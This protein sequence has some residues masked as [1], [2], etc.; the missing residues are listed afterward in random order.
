MPSINSRCLWNVELNH[1]TA[2]IL[3]Y[4][5]GAE[6][7][8]LGAASAFVHDDCR[9]SRCTWNTRGQASCAAVETWYLC[10]CCLRHAMVNGTKQHD[11]LSMNKCH[12]IQKSLLIPSEHEPTREKNG[13]GYI[14]ATFEKFDSHM[15]PTPYRA[16][17]PCKSDTHNQICVT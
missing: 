11:A 10:V 3:F 7:R 9:R 8:I 17:V 2:D 14:Y 6:A 16:A 12:E 13:S 5:F 4:T 15:S 1:T